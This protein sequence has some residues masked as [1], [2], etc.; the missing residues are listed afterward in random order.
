MCV[1][2]HFCTVQISG[3][4][5]KVITQRRMQHASTAKFAGGV[6]LSETHWC[7]TWT[8]IH[9]RIASSVISVGRASII[10]DHWRHISCCTQARNC[11]CVCV[12]NMWQGIQQTRVCEG[13]STDTYWRKTPTLVTYVACHSLNALLWLCTNT[14]TRDRDPISATFAIRALCS[15][16]YWAHIL[17]YAQH[18]ENPL[19]LS[20]VSNIWSSFLSEPHHEHFLTPACLIFTHH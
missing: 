13:A 17:R 9:G 20:E 15:R 14:I 7:L 10:G 2:R 4:T 5:S 1:V 16:L 11:V 6:S 12:W 19:L 8:R 18:N 3:S